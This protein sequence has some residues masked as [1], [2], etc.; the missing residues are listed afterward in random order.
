MAKIS[1]I[2][3]FL[4]IPQKVPTDDLAKILLPHVDKAKLYPLIKSQ[5]P[6][7]ALD[8][9]EEKDYTSILKIIIDSKG[10]SEILKRVHVNFHKAEKEH[11]FYQAIADYVK[12]TVPLEK[13][14]KGR[15]IE[16][17]EVGI[18]ESIKNKVFQKGE[19]IENC[20]LPLIETPEDISPYLN[21]LTT[22]DLGKIVLKKAK[23][24][25]P[26]VF[27]QRVI[28]SYS[29]NEA[30]AISESL[31]C[32]QTT[33]PLELVGCFEKKLDQQSEQDR[34]ESMVEMFKFISE[35]L[36]Q[37]TLLDMHIVFLSRISGA[38]DK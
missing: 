13:F 29:S 33:T 4:Y 11:D 28:Q 16:D 36:D 6:S 10:I 21:N 35:K 1:L 32:Q 9:L 31:W 24:E 12:Y 34:T 2:F 5:C 26:Q 22:L 23:Q 14:F 37:K 7:V 15:S 3:L 19:I 20:L 8:T 30:K 27:F 25:D 17:L 38:M 18:E